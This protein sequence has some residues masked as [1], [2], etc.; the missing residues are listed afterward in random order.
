MTTFCL[1]VRRRDLFGR[2]DVCVRWVSVIFCLLSFLWISVILRL[3]R[4]FA[5]VGFFPELSAFLGISDSNS[6][7]VVSF[8]GLVGLNYK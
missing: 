5:E 1:V 4:V 6:N 7:S 8:I 2:K 3:R